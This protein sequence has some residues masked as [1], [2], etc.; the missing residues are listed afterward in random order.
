[1]F[2]HAAHTASQQSLNEVVLFGLIGAFLTESTLNATFMRGL[3]ASDVASLFSLPITQKEELPQ[4]QQ[5]S[6]L[7]ALLTMEK[8]GA[9]AD[10]ADMLANVAYHAGAA[11]KDNEHVDLSSLLEKENLEDADT[12]LELASRN[13]TNVIQSLDDRHFVSVKRGGDEQMVELPFLKNARRMVSAVFLKRCELLGD[14]PNPTSAGSTPSKLQDM[15]AAPSVRTINT[16]L[17][18]GI[19]APRGGEEDGE[20][21]KKSGETD[22][23]SNGNSGGSG[24]GSGSS[25]IGREVAMRCAA[26]VACWQLSNTIQQLAAS[27][28]SELKDTVVTPIQLSIFLDSIPKTQNESDNNDDRS[29]FERF[30]PRETGQK[31]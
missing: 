2:E 12:S 14:V 26:V 10:Y 25:N 31:W 17:A 18:L 1:M 6:G 28:S 15:I 11:L 30:V 27:Q 21:E 13:L 16:L 23:T 7:S 22:S 5:D 9:L 24:S 19:L 8:R 4:E 20:D 29:T 3:S